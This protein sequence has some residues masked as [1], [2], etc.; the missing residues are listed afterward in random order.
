MKL[1]AELIDGEKCR[2]VD[3]YV[4][5]ETLLIEMGHPDGTYNIVK[6][7]LNDCNK[8]YWENGETI[9]ENRAS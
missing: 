3:W 5:S 2:V 4:I 8:L 1:M 7:H 6:C 9:Y